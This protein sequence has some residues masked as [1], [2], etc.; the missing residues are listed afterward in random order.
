MAASLCGQA[1]LPHSPIQEQRGS[2]PSPEPSLPAR[3]SEESHADEATKNA[4]SPC[5]AN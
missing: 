2:V 3:E 4:S 5:A 1:L